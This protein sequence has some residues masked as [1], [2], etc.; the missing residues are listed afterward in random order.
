VDTEIRLR[1]DGASVANQKEFVLVGGSPDTKAIVFSDPQSKDSELTSANGETELTYVYIDEVVKS[2]PNDPGCGTAVEHWVERLSTPSECDGEEATLY[3][4]TADPTEADVELMPSGG[5][6]PGYDIR[7]GTEDGKRYL[8][9]VL[10]S[11]DRCNTGSALYRRLPLGTGGAFVIGSDNVTPPVAS[12]TS[13]VAEVRKAHFPTK[14]IH[15]IWLEDYRYRAHTLASLPETISYAS[16]PGVEGARVPQI[17][18][19]MVFRRRADS[20]VQYALISYAIAPTN[21]SGADRADTSNDDFFPRE[22]AGAIASNAAPIRL[23]QDLRLVFDEDLG[24]YYV[25]LTGARATSLAFVATPGQ[26]LLFNGDAANTPPIPG[27]DGP[28]RVVSVRRVGGTEV[29]AYLDGPPRAGLRALTDFNAGDEF[30]AWVVQAKCEL[31]Q[32]VKPSS[33]PIYYWGLRPIEAR[34]FTVSP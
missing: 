28:V 6:N 15:E 34:L 2:L 10:R 11:V 7:Q 24:Q 4:W 32:K 33:T 23:V 27:A 14:F 29:R 12:A 5:G 18:Y 16:T 13:V 21:P 3:L 25:E 31:M 20:S 19:S 22:D 17:G 8:Y 26:V 1:W 30:D 9:A